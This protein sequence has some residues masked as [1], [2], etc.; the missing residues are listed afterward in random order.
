LLLVST[1]SDEFESSKLMSRAAAGRVRFAELS[2][3]A[4]GHEISMNPRP[5]VQ[6][7]WAAARSSAMGR[8]GSS[9]ASIKRSA[10]GVTTRRRVRPP[11]SIALDQDHGQPP[12]TGHGRWRVRDAPSARVASLASSAALPH[13]PADAAHPAQLRGLDPYASPY[14]G[15]PR[16]P[17]VP[18]RPHLCS[19]VPLRGSGAARPR[20]CA[21]RD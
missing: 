18:A 12:A 9:T 21:S 8:P 1:F 17:P 10:E 3:Q 16:T 20:G 2:M 14:A 15:Y 4:V 11:A 6:A 5:A 13:P 19:S 7:G